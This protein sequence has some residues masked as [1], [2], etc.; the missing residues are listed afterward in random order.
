MST[1]I[2]GSRVCQL[3][4]ARTIRSLS[5]GSGSRPFWTSPI[6]ASV[7]GL[8]ARN[9]ELLAGAET[10]RMGA[11]NLDRAAVDHPTDGFAR[12]P[13]ACDRP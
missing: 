12:A 7:E 13:R 10:P 6:G 11:Q 8:A 4:L 3:A 5:L 2:T 9:D 1:H